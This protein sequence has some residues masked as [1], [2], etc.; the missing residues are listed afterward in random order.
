MFTVVPMKRINAKHFRR[1]I[2]KLMQLYNS[3]LTGNQMLSPSSG[4]LCLVVFE[5]IHYKCAC[6]CCSISFRIYSSLVSVLCRRY[7]PVFVCAFL[8]MHG[9]ANGAKALS[10]PSGFDFFV[11]TI[12]STSKS[13]WRSNVSADCTVFICKV[14]GSEVVVCK[15]CMDCFCDF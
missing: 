15:I 13:S 11:R 5:H 3:V 10:N 4:F 14:V 2:L 9:I 12:E 1:L 7:T 8:I 6:C